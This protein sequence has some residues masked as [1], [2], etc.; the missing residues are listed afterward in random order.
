M[1]ISTKLNAVLT[2]AVFLCLIISALG[3]LDMKSSM[4]VD[5]KIKTKQ[6]VEATYSLVEYYYSLSTDG[7]GQLSVEEAQNQA[8]QAISK[9]RYDEKEYF[10]INDTRPFMVMHPYKPELNGKD[11]SQ[12][13]RPERKIPV[14]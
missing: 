2:F 9:L 14:C 4:L 10:W 5:R 11:L 7:G 6:L 13:Q 8:K 1:N 12:I 3:I